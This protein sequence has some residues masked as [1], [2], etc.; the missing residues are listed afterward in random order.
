MLGKSASFKFLE[1]HKLSQ[2]FGIQKVPSD[3]LPDP[4][5]QTARRR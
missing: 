4:I 2:D 5:L 1:L 3:T